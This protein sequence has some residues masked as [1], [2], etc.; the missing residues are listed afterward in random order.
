MSTL[1]PI[2]INSLSAS[3]GTHLS[4]TKKTSYPFVKNFNSTETK[5]TTPKQ[6][7]NLIQKTA[8]AGDCLIKGTLTRKLHDESRARST[9]SNLQTQ[10]ICFDLDGAAFKNPEEFIQELPKA[11][12]G[13]SYTCQYS[14]SQGIKSG[15]RCHLF[16]LMMTPVYPVF[17]KTWLKHLNFSIPT[18]TASL[19][20]TSTNVALLWPL[21]ITVC[22]NDKIIYVAPPQDR[23]DKKCPTPWIIFVPKKKS[24]VDFTGIKF[25]A[26][27]TKLNE[28]KY[29]NELRK[30]DGLSPKRN[31]TSKKIGSLTVLANPGNCIVTGHRED[32]GFHYLNLNGGDSWGYYHPINQNQILYNFKGEPLYLIKELL[33]EYYEQLTGDKVPVSEK[34]TTSETD[35]SSFKYLAFCD[36]K[37]DSYYRGIYDEVNNYLELFKTN[38]LTKLH[39][40]LKQHGQPVPDFVPEWDLIYDFDSDVLV[41]EDEQWVNRYQKTEYLKNWSKRATIPTLIEKLI[42]HVVNYD[43]VVYAR[44][45]NWLACIIQTRRQTGTAWV[46]HGTQGTGKGILFNKLLL[47]ILGE[48]FVFRTK[49]DSFEQEFNGYMEHSLLILVD[50]TQISDLNRSSKAMAA[51]KQYITDSS[52]SI[53]RMRT[54]PY[55]VKNVSSFIFNSNKHDPIQIDPTDR[56]FNVAPRQETP[57]LGNALTSEQIDELCTE[58]SIQAFCDFLMSYKV[59]KKLAATVIHTTERKRLMSLTQDAAEE[60]VHSLKNGDINFFID[61]APDSEDAETMKLKLR[62]REVRTYEEIINDCVDSARISGPINLSRTDLEVLCYYIIGTEYPTRHKFTKYIGHKGLSITAVN[63]NNTTTRGVRELIFGHDKKA[64]KRWDDRASAKKFK[65]K[66]KVIPIKKNTRA[67]KNKK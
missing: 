4:K 41:H 6:F 56:R 34:P 3:N 22:Q 40:F 54:D 50:E 45:I 46:L 36:A 37:T 28:K 67:K 12:H 58:D 13:V 32:R 14:A 2:L 24:R 27:E 19:Q 18:L 39:H 52:V 63:I 42:Q 38:S 31:F 17:L 21:D 1:S 57:L 29:V 66:A 26:N 59:N 64:I 11:F 16:F 48:D 8:T 65:Q 23:K 5:I 62:I 30:A 44:L 51:I 15:L 53:R 33:P 20:L 9:N 35:A 55:I 60:L 61:N 7:F 47:P 43:G 10:W 25:D 49:L